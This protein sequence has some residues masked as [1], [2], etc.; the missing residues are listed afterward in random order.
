MTT[1][2]APPAQPLPAG[3]SSLSPV[4]VPAGAALTLKQQAIYDL[5]VAGKTMNE[6]AHILGISTPVVNKTLGVCYRKLGLS[7]RQRPEITTGIEHRNPEI[8]AAA[9][10]AAADPSA[11]SLT[12]AINRVNAQLKAAG[13]PDKVSERLIRRLRVKYADAITATRELK[14]NEILQMLGNK[15]DLA[16]YYLD[17][18]VMAEA[19][20]R[21]IM[22]GLG[23]LIEKRNLLKGEATAIISHHERKHLHELM[24]LLIAEG[25]RRGI[26]VEGHVTAKEVS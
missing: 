6:I 18:K 9:I 20:A 12:E 11:P 13:L 26:T 22:L 2:A 10:Q 24:P 5:K 19:S 4:V 8:A 21:D 17:D 25:Q 16:A 14:T 15:I 3:S 23:V 1:D 7:K